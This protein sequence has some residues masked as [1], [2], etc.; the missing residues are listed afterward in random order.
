MKSTVAAVIGLLLLGSSEPASQPVPG[1]LGFDEQVLRQPDITLRADAVDVRIE[2]PFALAPESF[3]A[4]IR[5]SGPRYSVST[6]DPAVVEKVIVALKSVRFS[7]RPSPRS[8]IDSRLRLR[9]EK[10]QEEVLTLWIDRSGHVLLSGQFYEAPGKSQWLR[11]LW[12]ALRGA[13][14]YGPP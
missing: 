2:V 12:E 11:E 14:R 5:S 6:N 8:G 13:G 1:P 10:R 4:F 3:D 7:P 9:F